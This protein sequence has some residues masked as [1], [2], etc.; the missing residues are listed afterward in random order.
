[1][2]HFFGALLWPNGLIFSTFLNCS[3]EILPGRFQ[4]YFVS[5][6]LVTAAIKRKQKIPHFDHFPRPG[7]SDPYVSCSGSGNYPRTKDNR[8]GWSFQQNIGHSTETSSCD[9]KL[10][11]PVEQNKAS[12]MLLFATFAPRCTSC[13]KKLKHSKCWNWFKLWNAA[14]NVFCIPC[15]SHK[16]LFFYLGRKFTKNDTSQ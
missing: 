5:N 1:M 2:W 10:T 14:T 3:E 8:V 6:R 12:K 7:E 9:M 11:L 15:K 13:Y 16:M 4:K